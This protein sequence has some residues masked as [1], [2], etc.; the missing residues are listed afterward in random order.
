MELSFIIIYGVTEKGLKL[1]GKFFMGYLYLCVVVWAISAVAFAL[2]G[3]LGLIGAWA[4]VLWSIRA[5]ETQN[6]ITFAEQFKA[7]EELRNAIKQ[8]VKVA[9]EKNKDIIKD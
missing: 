3:F 4:I 5:M 2:G 6:G 8:G 1:M 7:E 9:K